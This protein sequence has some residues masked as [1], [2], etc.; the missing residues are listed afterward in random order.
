MER[1]ARGLALRRERQGQTG[2]LGRVHLERGGAAGRGEGGKGRG[3][4]RGGERGR[5][6]R[7][8]GKGGEG[9]GGGRATGL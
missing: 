4:R 6:G 9:R 8:E 3:R 7:G 5:E 2:K 1:K